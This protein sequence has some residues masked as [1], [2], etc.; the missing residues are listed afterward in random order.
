MNSSIQ[1]TTNQQE[2]VKCPHCSKNIILTRNNTPTFISINSIPILSSDNILKFPIVQQSFDIIQNHPKFNGNAVI[3][4]SPI[5]IWGYIVN[6]HNQ[7][8]MDVSNNI[9]QL[10]NQN[11]IINC[12]SLH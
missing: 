12:G 7:L 4:L 10:R 1:E 6:P 11:L 3:D 9:V 2:V 8:V 5:N